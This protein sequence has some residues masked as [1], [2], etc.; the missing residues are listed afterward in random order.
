MLSSANLC[1][2]CAR[3]FFNKERVSQLQKQPPEVFCEKR[4]SYKFRKIHRK[5]P[6]TF[7]KFL[8]KNT[9]LTEHVWATASLIVKI[10]LE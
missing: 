2:R 8:T 5:T 7:A 9:F 10:T 4:C 6:V 3:D 1:E